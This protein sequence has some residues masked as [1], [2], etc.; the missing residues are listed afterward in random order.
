MIESREKKE[1]IEQ[2]REREKYNLC[3]L[4]FVYARKR[5]E[6]KR[7]EKEKENLR[8]NFGQTKIVTL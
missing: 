2:R 7:F 8:V 3:W 5:N 6:R 4:C 1:A